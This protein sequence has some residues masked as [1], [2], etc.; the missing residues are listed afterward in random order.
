MIRT[1][2]RD[3]T[4][5]GGKPPLPPILDPPGVD[6]GPMRRDLKRQIQQLEQ[7]I[8]AFH[9]ENCPY[10]AFTASPVRGPAVLTN[11]Q[12]EQVRDEL[13]EIRAELHERVTQRDVDTMLAGLEAATAEDLGIIERLKRRLLGKR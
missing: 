6:E 8:A 9:V 12:L 11:A 1:T 3:T 7:D 5:A 10:E 2:D 4:D 13:T